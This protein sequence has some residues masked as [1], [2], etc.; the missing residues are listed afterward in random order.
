MTKEYQETIFSKIISK[1]IPADIV[2][3]DDLVTAFRDIS[4]QAKTHILIIPNK[5]IPTVNH[6]TTEDEKVLGRLI[7]TAAKIAKQEGISEDGYRLIMNCNQH[8]GQEVFH[9][10][11]HL[12]GGEPLGKMLSK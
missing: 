11:M 5:F 10:H 2:Y 8:G 9:I 4:P 7:T 3:Q 12:V 1:E 6:V